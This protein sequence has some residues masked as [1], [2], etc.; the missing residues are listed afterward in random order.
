MEPHAGTPKT[1]KQAHQ[2]NLY[3]MLLARTVQEPHVPRVARGGL[4]LLLPSQTS[5]P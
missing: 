4:L 5:K 2:H 1:Q 3:G